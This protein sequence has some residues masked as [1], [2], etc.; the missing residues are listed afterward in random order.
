MPNWK[1]VIVSGSDA[2]LHSLYLDSNLTASIVSAS[3]FTGSFYGDGSNLSGIV[4]DD[5]LPNNGWDFNTDDST[6]INDFQTASLVYL[7]DFNNLPLAGTE[8]GKIGWFGDLTGQTQLIPTTNG[9]YILANDQTTGYITSQGYSGSIVG[10][11]NVMNF[12]SS[13]DGRLSGF[14]TT[15]SNIFNGDQI[16]TGSVFISGATEFGGNLVPKESQGATLG[17]SERPFKGIFVSSGSINIASDIPGDPNT[18][19]SNIGGN[20]LVSAGGMKLVEPG[21]SFIA[22][23]GSFQYISGSMTQV[24]NYTQLGNHTLTGNSTI[25]GSLSI[26]NNL[27]ASGL[28]YP[29]ADNGAESFIQTDGAGT[30]S[31]QYVKTMYQNIRNRESVTINKGTPLFASGST[32]DNVDVYI[33]DA[34]NPLRM[35]A[36]LIAGDTTLAAGA[37]GKGIIFGHI[38]GVDTNAYPAGTQVY[39]GVGGGWTVTRPTGSSTP[40][41]PLGIVTRQGNNGMGIVMTEA[42]NSLPN[43]QSGYMWV[44]G[45]DNQP[46]T[47][48]TASLA[49]TG[50]NALTGSQIVTGSLIVTGSV[51]GNVIA[52]S[53]TSGTASIDFRAGTFFTLTIPS[54]AITHITASNMQPGLTANLILTQQAT[55]GSVRWDSGF[56]FPSGS[57]NTGSAS[58]S[59]VD[60][61]S[62]MMVNTS[63]ILSVGANRIQ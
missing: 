13:V 11:G 22:E 12:S 28:H 21:N 43:L 39:V 31:L 62:M 5:G 23:T 14:A 20:I 15:G 63:Q 19:L 61:V 17:T 42:P 35:P 41:Q 27:T 24:G 58:G 57:F 48:S 55:T 9:L 8:A 47:L 40:V 54:S 3:Q 60:I 29:I 44:G 2:S 25:S 1:K 37:T 36:T 45:S 46:V 18:T 51:A 50:S 53:V 6:P 32:G 33:A 4:V 10:I 49:R 26:T 30:L 34:G 38:Q 52:L 7:I 59:A 56:K 16:I